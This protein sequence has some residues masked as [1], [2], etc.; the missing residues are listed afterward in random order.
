MAVGI[1]WV[2]NVSASMAAVMDGMNRTDAAGSAA[3]AGKTLRD[4][5]HRLRRCAAHPAR[6][7]WSARIRAVAFERKSMSATVAAGRRRPLG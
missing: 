4:G 5:V 7:P 6:E 1:T 2:H 3:W